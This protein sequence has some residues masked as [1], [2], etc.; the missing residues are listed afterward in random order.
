MGEDDATEAEN[1]GDDGST[2]VILKALAGNLAIAATKLI[3]ALITGAS[4]MFAETVHSLADTGNQGLLLIGT[5]RSR[6]PA[7]E[8]HPFGYGK[9]LY[10]WSF[11]VAILLF[12]LGSGV[13]IYEG[14]YKLLN[15]HPIENHFVAFAVLIA[16][17][18]FEGYAFRSAVREAN[19]RRGTRGIFAWVRDSKDSGLFTVLFEDAS[20]LMGLAIALGMLG[21]A[22][23]F[24]MPSLDA[25]ASIAVG[26]L[27]AA[28]AI[29]LAAQT[30][31]LLVGE[32]A[33]PEV[34]R[35]LRET[36]AS[37]PRIAA[38]NDALTMHL[39]PNAVLATI[40]LDFR[41]RLDS[42]EV[43]RA[44]TELEARIKEGRPEIR[45][46]FVEA[47]SLAAHRRMSPE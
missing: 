24:D 10:F 44:V 27:L 31:S 38:V 1:A 14:V 23:Y 5:K 19:A 20:A 8:Q 30:K 40:S 47:Q 45:H 7:D 22:V 15:P 17:M 11:V 43:E 39:G 28:A 25:W 16:A 46:V 12:S 26:L 21:A 32:A 2:G 42:G 34:R 35:F 4:A 18:G 41:E 3:A 36:A 29:T 9:E 33:K 37:D 13:S 6:R